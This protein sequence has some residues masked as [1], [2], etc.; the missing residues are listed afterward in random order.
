MGRLTSCNRRPATGTRTCIYC[1]ETKPSGAFNREHVMHRAFG[2]F[3]GNNLV[4]DCVCKQC[5]DFFA[6]NIDRKF[7]RDSVE[8]LFR[9][10]MGIKSTAKFTRVP[11]ATTRVEFREGDSVGAV[12]HLTRSADGG[13]ELGVDFDPYFALS[14]AEDG[15]KTWFARDA[16]PARDRLGEHGF[17]KTPFCVHT[18]GMSVEEAA[19]VLQAKGYT[20]NHE[21]RTWWPQEERVATNTI[22]V[23][24]VPEM[25]SA[26]KIAMNYLAHIAGPAVARAVQFDDVRRFVRHERGFPNVNVSENN[27][28]VVRRDHGQAIRG[29]YVAVQTQPNGVILAQVSVLQKLKYIIPLSTSP[30]AVALPALSHG[31]AWD[32]DAHT[33]K[34]FDV[35]PFT[36]GR[37]LK[38]R[39]AFPAP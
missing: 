24:G 10:L 21:F 36:P 28:Q 27:V 7:G 6:E 5:N 15:P 35:P 26:A 4:L 39:S 33:V 1:L 9:F 19:A 30:F 22:G 12:G 23:I 18:R 8:G 11:D 14:E 2:S 13:P 32:I 20:A 17:G 3:T 16:L 37:A 29:H 34:A 31:H 25:R 38:P